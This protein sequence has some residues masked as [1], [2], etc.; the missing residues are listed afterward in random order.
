MSLSNTILRLTS[1]E[2][3]TLSEIYAYAETLPKGDWR[4]YEKCKKLLY[5]VVG[6]MAEYESGIKAICGI[7]R[8]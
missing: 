1:C 3:A 5:A 7:L 2:A 4:G 8:V 6:T